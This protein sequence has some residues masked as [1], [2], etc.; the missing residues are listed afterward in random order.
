H[1]HDGP[2]SRAGRVFGAAHH[3]WRYVVPAT[4]SRDET[5]RAHGQFTRAGDGPRRN[6]HRL[7]GAGR[8]PFLGR[9]RACRSAVDAG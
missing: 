5:V 4:D 3:Q 8:G 7:C 1:C 6:R 2:W 9:I